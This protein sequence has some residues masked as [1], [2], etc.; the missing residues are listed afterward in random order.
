M[1]IEG[2]ITYITHHD[3]ISDDVKYIA[4]EALEKQI[5]KKPIEVE[6][7]H[8]NNYHCPKCYSILG[9]TVEVYKTKYCNCGQAIDWSE[10]K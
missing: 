2:A 6:G 5:K 9:N 7:K 3:F 10:E 4:I 1:T 8:W